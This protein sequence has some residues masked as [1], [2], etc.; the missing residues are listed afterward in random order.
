[1]VRRAEINFCIGG[2]G[3]KKPGIELKDVIQNLRDQL[4]QS[5]AAADG[6][7]L[8]LVVEEMELELQVVVTKGV[9]GEVSVE[10]GVKFWVLNALGGAKGTGSFESSQLQTLRLKLRPETEE[11]V[12][13][14]ATGE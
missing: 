1:M 5:V 10:G 12:V 14:L 13:M 4:K 8:R 9:E 2:N 7:D 3:M 6:E 11:G